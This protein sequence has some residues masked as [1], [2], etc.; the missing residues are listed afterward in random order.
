VKFDEAE[1]LF[2]QALS[3]EETLSGPASIKIGR[4]LAELAATLAARKKWEE[5]FACVERLTRF[6]ADYASGERIFL[7]K[8]FQHYA[9]QARAM[10]RLDLS[11]TLEA[12]AEALRPAN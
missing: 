2:R 10:S 4:R 6:D 7:T 12:S 8:L 3:L 1:G 5:G 11:A 9:K